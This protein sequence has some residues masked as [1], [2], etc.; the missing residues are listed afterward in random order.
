MT[1]NSLTSMSNLAKQHL[2]Q[3]HAGVFQGIDYF[4]ASSH[5]SLP[6]IRP[7]AGLMRPDRVK[8]FKTPC[9]KVL[10]VPEPAVD[11][12]L[13]TN[14]RKAEQRTASPGIKGI[15]DVFDEL[16]CDLEEQIESPMDPLQFGLPSTMACAADMTL[17]PRPATEHTRNPWAW[18]TLGDLFTLCGPLL[19]GFLFMQVASAASVAYLFVKNTSAEPYWPATILALVMLT[20]DAL[21]L[22]AHRGTHYATI[23]RPLAKLALITILPGVFAFIWVKLS[24]IY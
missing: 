10:H 24:S 20:L 5:G 19:T 4:S 23:F 9:L 8:R 11:V 3:G 7:L 6:T 15:E 14:G 22:K 12:V 13:D 2:N 17:S 1:H 16:S 18:W 21:L